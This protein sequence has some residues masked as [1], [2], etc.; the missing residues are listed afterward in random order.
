MLTHSPPR[1]R[2]LAVAISAALLG[3]LLTGLGVARL[4]QS[5][6]S[7]QLVLWTTLPLIGAPLTLWSMYHAYGLV[8]AGYGLDREGFYLRWGWSRERIPL[9]LIESVRSVSRSELPTPP[10]PRLPGFLLGAIRGDDPQLEYFATRADRLVLV[11]HRD[12]SLVISPS[13]PAAFVETFAACTRLGSLEA[14]EPVSERPNLLPAKM[15]FDVTARAL[16]LIGL[17]VPLGLLGYLGVMSP[18]LPSEI[19][20]GFGPDTIPGPPVPAGRLLLLP[21]VGGLIWLLDLV[22]GGWF[23]RRPEHRPVAY[24]AW[25]IAVLIGLLLWVGGLSMLASTT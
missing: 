12:R 22:L 19:P 11:E 4:T 21:L 15:W 16:I 18:T 20:F 13:D 7:P 25:G 9:R 1:A 5:G 14:L 3:A 10:W 23:Y 17:L 24:A 6:F 8:L 2:S